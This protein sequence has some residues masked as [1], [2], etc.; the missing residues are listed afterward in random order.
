MIGSKFVALALAYI[1]NHYRTGLVSQTCKRPMTDTSHQ[2]P[3]PHFLDRQLRQQLID[4]LKN[5]DDFNL[6]EVASLANQ[7]A[8][9]GETVLSIANSSA[10]GLRRKI[11]TAQHAVLFLGERRIRKVAQRFLQRK[12]AG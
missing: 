4:N 11:K 6:L 3:R 5:E 8:A 9:F 12:I 10:M 2:T 1:Q 7:Y